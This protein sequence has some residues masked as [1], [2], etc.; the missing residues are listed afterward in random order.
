MET[1]SFRYR[2]EYKG[3]PSGI[4]I[5]IRLSVDSQNVVELLA[6]LDTGAE[7]CIFQ[8]DYADLLGLDI[9]SGVFKRFATAIGP[10]DTY[11]HVVKLS[12]YEHDSEAMVYFSSSYDFHRNVLGREGWFNKLR[13]GLVHYDELLFFSQYDD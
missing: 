1:L 9:E 11:G 3:S 7:N 2:Y 13:F 6:A 5:P 10:F 12:C 8:R 4:T